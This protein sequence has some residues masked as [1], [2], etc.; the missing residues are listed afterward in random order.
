MEERATFRATDPRGSAGSWLVVVASLACSIAFLIALAAILPLRH[1]LLLVAIAAWFALPGV[2]FVRRASASRG[3]F[4]FVIGA[5]WGYAFSCLALL[6]LWVAGVRSEALLLVVAPFLAAAIALP[7]ARFVELSLPARDRRD[8]LV[9]LLLL[10]LV[11]LLVGRPFA[12]VGELTPD[13]R[14]YRAYFTADFIWRMAVTAELAKGDVPPR[15]QFFLGDDLRYYWLPDLLPAVEYRALGRALRLEQVLLAHGIVVDAMFIAF[16]FAF[17]RHWTTSATAAGLGVAAAVLFTSFEGIE[18]IIAFAR[19]GIDYGFLRMLNI[20]AI[21]RWNY[22]SLPVDGL[23]RVLFWQPQHAMGYALGFSALVVVCQ[24]L[25]R[26]TSRSAAAMGLAGVLLATALFFSSFSAIMLG[27]IVGCVAAAR[28]AAARRWS[29]MAAGALAAAVP[30]GAAVLVALTLHYV[31]RGESIVRLLVNPAA[32]SHPWLAIFLSFGPML[33]AVVVGSWLG[34]RAGKGSRLAPLWA[35]VIVAFLFYFF[36]DVRDHQYVYVGWRAGHLL[37]ISFA[38]L[39]AVALQE[40]WRRGPAIRV[41]TASVALILAAAAAPTLA[42]DV[43]NAQDTDNRGQGPGFPWTLVLTPDEL[44]AI[45]WLRRSTPPDAI[46]QVEPYVRGRA[47]W[48]YLPAFAE[49]RMAAGLPTSMVPLDKY[50]AASARVREVYMARDARD[51]YRAAVELRIEYLVVGPPERHAYPSFEPLLD[52]RPEL[53]RRVFKNGSMTIYFVER[54]RSR[55]SGRRRCVTM[56]AFLPEDFVP[57][58]DA[59]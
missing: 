52:A 21:T 14:T 58:G 20:D 5:V 15:N 6:A 28:F 35:A 54:D 45:D 40:L 39:T 13:G 46:V 47:T 3:L 38:P 19:E 56:P 29:A 18:R 43:Y 48:A 12:R 24:P 16:L 42:V 26:T 55:V 57:R 30:I 9:L 53:F 10:L 49:R 25:P 32:M 41:V 59:C 11:P 36:V 23:Q 1:A 4:P 33:P 27:C 50:E 44:V 7:A 2:A 51:A 37:F 34:A 17:A 8:L 22:G 31:D